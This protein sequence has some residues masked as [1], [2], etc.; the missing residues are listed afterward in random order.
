M[1]P[2]TRLD[3]TTILLNEEHILWIELQH[4]TVLA[5]STGL[6]LRVQEPPDELMRRI[7]AW[8]RRVAPPA[9]LPGLDDDAIE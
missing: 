7:A 9:A 6:V 1:I 4:D 8:R 5:L 2:V 3:G